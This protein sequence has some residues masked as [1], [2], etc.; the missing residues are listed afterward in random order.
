[1]SLSKQ[2]WLRGLW[3]V[4]LLVLAALFLHT[5]SH[6]EVLPPH[7]NLDLFPDR[8]GAWTGDRIVI[9][10]AD[11]AVLGPGR[12]LERRYVAPDKPAIDL[13]IAYFPTQTT[14]D[15]IHSPKHCLPGAGWTPFYSTVVRVP[16]GNGKTLN[17]NY[18]A[19]QLG[20][21]R[22]VVLYWFQS[23]GRTTASEYWEKFYLVADALRTNRTDGALVRV[24]TGLT[25]REPLASAEQR[26]LNFTRQILPL[27][28]NY[29][30]R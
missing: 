28:G 23:H 18:Y 24:I 11:L 15:Q 20:S 1:V 2:T 5:H 6:A 17:A 13:F 12:F 4:L 16:W 8:I 30:P 27:L 10:Q 7:R 29:I 22:E 21:D 9:P 3:P 19:L 14:G 26:A 25:D